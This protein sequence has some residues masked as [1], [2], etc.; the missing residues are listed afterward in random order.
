MEKFNK[1]ITGSPCVHCR[2]V[3]KVLRKLNRK[4]KPQNRINI[5]NIKDKKKFNVNRYPIINELKYSNEDE[6][7]TPNLSLGKIKN[8][9]IIEDISVRG[10]YEKEIMVAFFNGYMNNGLNEGW[11]DFYEEELKEEHEE[12][13]GE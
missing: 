3:N 13:F 8:N 6:I 10:E 4:L 7:G 11:K 9:Q 5:N 1:L 12:V 2:S